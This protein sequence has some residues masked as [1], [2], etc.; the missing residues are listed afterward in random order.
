MI[1]WSSFYNHHIELSFLKQEGCQFWGICCTACKGRFHSFCR[2]K[3]HLMH[4]LMSICTLLVLNGYWDLWS[5]LIL[6]TFWLILIPIL[7]TKFSITSNYLCSTSHPGVALF[8]NQLFLFFL[9]FTKFYYQALGYWKIGLFWK[10]SD[11][12]LGSK[13]TMK[14]MKKMKKLKKHN[15]VYFI[16]IPGSWSKEERHFGL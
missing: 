10:C 16:S 14:K 15:M 2:G 3:S 11:I 4:I 5:N 1:I 7:S 8:V 9:S 6:S 12:P 13:F